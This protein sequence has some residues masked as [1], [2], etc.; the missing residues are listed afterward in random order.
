MATRRETSGRRRPAPRLYLVTEQTDSAEFAAALA[1]ALAA[2]DIA[3]ILLSLS[4]DGEREK[5]NQIKLLAP[6][7]QD[8]GAA[9]LLYGHPDLVARA[10]AD[11]VHSH[12][13]EALRETISGLKPGRIAGV[14]RLNTRHD[15]MLAA[16]IGA[17]YVMFGEPDEAQDRPGFDSIL[18]RVA[19]WSELF[20]VPCVGYAATLEEIGPLAIA[21]AD[22]VALGADLWVGAAGSSNV[23]EAER[24]LAVEEAL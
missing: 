21:G 10:G 2:A 5:I 22:F 16:E 11:G 4:G 23:R 20:E 6:V 3:A 15:S 19:W 24:R 9:M 18:D 17:D 12:G 7:I 1:A 14:G 13:I 8:R